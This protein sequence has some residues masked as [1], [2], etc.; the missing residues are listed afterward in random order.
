[1]VN[2]GREAGAENKKT[3]DC[4]LC[5]FFDPAKSYL[6]GSYFDG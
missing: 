1:M 4:L 5:G 3:A 2:I 6:A